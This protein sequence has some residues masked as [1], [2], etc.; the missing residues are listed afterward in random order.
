MNEDK[1]KGDQALKNS[2]GKLQCDFDVNPFLINMVSRVLRQ[3]MWVKNKQS[4]RTDLLLQNF[5]QTSHETVTE[6]FKQMNSSVYLMVNRGQM[7]SW[8]LLVLLSVQSDNS[9]DTSNNPKK[10]LVLQNSLLP[11]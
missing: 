5:L 1:Q 3:H 9:F 11:T 7:A 10:A 2:V 4:P 6:A 8:V